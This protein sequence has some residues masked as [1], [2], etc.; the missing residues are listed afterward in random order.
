MSVRLPNDLL[1]RLDQAGPRSAVIVAALRAYLR[2]QAPQ[3]PA[4]ASKVVTNL[5]NLD[6][7]LRIET[8]PRI[9]SRQ[10]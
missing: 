3:G 2:R 7:A 10:V 8:G 9:D 4:G 5:N 6:P 1:A